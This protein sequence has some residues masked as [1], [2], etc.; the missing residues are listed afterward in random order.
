MAI[1]HNERRASVAQSGRV[2]RSDVAFKPK[3]LVAESL[4]SDVISAKHCTTA[5]MVITQSQQETTLWIWGGT[6]MVHGAG[7]KDA[8]MPIQVIETPVRI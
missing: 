8:P 3:D 2:K 6:W 5:V 7:L 4:G 1:T